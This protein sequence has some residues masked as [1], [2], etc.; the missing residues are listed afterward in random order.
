ML[1]PPALDSLPVLLLRDIRVD[2]RPELV[3]E[4]VGALPYVVIARFLSTLR[5]FPARDFEPPKGELSP[6]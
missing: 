6:S 3:L 5:R 4:A 1:V 2:D